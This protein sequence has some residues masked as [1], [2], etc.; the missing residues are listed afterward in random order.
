[1]KIGMIIPNLISLPPDPRK[2]PKGFSGAPE[3]ISW[4]LTEQLVKK[5]HEVTLFASGDSRTNAKLVPAGAQATSLGPEITYI[6]RTDYEY[7]LIGE[8]L[9][10]AKEQGFDVVHSQIPLRTALF[11][12]FFPC[13]V[14]TTL[15]SQLRPDD[16]I[17][18]HHPDDQFYISLSDAQ[19]KQLPK[20][21]YLATIY[22]GLDLNDYPF[23]ERVEDRL[24][25]I[26][27]IVPDKGLHHAMEIS[28]L[29]RLPL[30]IFGDNPPEQKDYFNR[31]ILT[32]K[33]HQTVFHGFVSQVKVRA[34]LRKAKILL[35]PIQW[36]EPFGLGMIEAMASGTPV[37]GFSRGSVP[38]IVS[39]RETGILVKPGDRRGLLRAVDSIMNLPPANYLQLRQKC[40]Q[41]VEEHFT[42]DEMVDNYEKAYQ[43]A[44]ERFSQ[45]S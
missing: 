19:R 10:L 39:D 22:H 12:R 43:Q 13:P 37:V 28:N 31:E 20:L 45:L 11:A 40:R 18:S 44:I 42:V 8:A 26:G 3:A 4:F 14:V 24:I 9:R 1:M 23:S 17:Y 41:R 35:F 33:T 7:W 6:R 38:E 5:K 15:H 2:I 16:E 34:A 30:D 21:N 27:R 25:F 36:E 32:R 29:L